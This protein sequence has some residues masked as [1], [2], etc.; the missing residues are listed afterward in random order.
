MIFSY[1]GF[2]KQS[3]CV[4]ALLKTAGYDASNFAFY[5]RYKVY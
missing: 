4:T 1:F 5:L 3:S 2:F